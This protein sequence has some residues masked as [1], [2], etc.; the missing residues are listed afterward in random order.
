MSAAT[1]LGGV[2]FRWR[3]FT[4]LLLAPLAV[5][6]LWSNRGAASPL[7]IAAGFAL[8]ALG[9]ALRGWVLGQVPDGTSGQNE[10]LIVSP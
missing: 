7:W 10:V 5:A 6:A 4:P 8:C 3:S 1:R 9:Q 2:L